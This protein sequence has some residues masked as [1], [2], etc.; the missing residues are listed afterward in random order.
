MRPIL[1]LVLVLALV[2]PSAAAHA[3][4]DIERAWAALSA[5]GHALVMRHARAPGTGDPS[6][7]TLGNCSTQRTLDDAGRAQARRIGE[8]LRAHGIDERPVL[9]SRWCRCRETARLLDVGPVAPLDGLNSFYGDAYKEADVMPMLRAFLRLRPLDPPPVL[10]T[11]QVVI[12]ALT[13]EFAS[14]G[15]MFVVR[16]AD[17]GSVTVVGRI[18][19][20]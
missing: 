15:E 13:G 2:V 11:H 8:R 16:V 4:D 7:F 6:G 19:P 17:D 10:V 12:T 20:A 3:A 14:E 5:P 18:P 9:T 1:W